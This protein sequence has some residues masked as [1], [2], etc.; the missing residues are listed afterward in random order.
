MSYAVRALRDGQGATG[1]TIGHVVVAGW[2]NYV[3]EIILEDAEIGPF[4]ADCLAAQARSRAASAPLEEK[5]PGPYD[6]W[7]DRGEAEEI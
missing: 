2:D 3:A 5:M 6:H 4:I 7:A 1:I